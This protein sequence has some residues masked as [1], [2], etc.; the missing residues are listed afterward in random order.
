[1]AEVGY[2]FGGGGNLVCPSFLLLTDENNLSAALKL[3]QRKCCCPANFFYLLFAATMTDAKMLTTAQAAQALRAAGIDVGDSTVRLWATQGYFPNAV[4]H[5]SPSGG[6]WMIPETE[7]QGFEKPQ[8]GRPP[9]P[10]EEEG[11]GSRKRTEKR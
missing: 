7:L 5:E 2:V 3:C 8:R 11:K 6:F 10:K 9:K 1:V 4:K